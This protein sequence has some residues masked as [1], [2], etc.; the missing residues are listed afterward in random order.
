MSENDSAETTT[1]KLPRADEAKEILRGAIGQ[2]RFAR[3]YTLE[4]LDSTPEE[5][6]FT[7]PDGLPS[8]IAWQAGHLAVSQYGL[9]MFRIRGREPDD[10]SLIPGKFRKAFGRGSTPNASPEGQPTPSELYER[11]AKI[12]D[13]GVDTVRDLAPEVLLEPVE[14]PYAAYP[15]KLGAILFC[16]LHEQI[17][18]GQIGLIRRA[19]GLDPIR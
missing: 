7:I 1:G 2:I 8:H 18:A 4:L 16:P 5:L 17:H 6:W 12:F 14:M 9:L 3:D 10:L 15:I 19:L 11:L 13:L